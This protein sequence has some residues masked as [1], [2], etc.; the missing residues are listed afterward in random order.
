MARR[1]LRVELLV[2]TECGQIGK[3]PNA[4]AAGIKGYCTG[5]ADSSHSKARM[6]PVHFVEERGK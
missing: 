3:V 1:L 6:V 5:G 4:G 2:C